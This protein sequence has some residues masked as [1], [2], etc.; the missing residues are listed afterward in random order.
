MK[1]TMIRRF[2]LLPAVLM[3]LAIFWLSSRTSNELNSVLP[4]FQELFPSMSNFDWGHFIAYF[5]LGLSYAYGFGRHAGRPS[6]KAFIILLCVVY[7]LTDEY[8][9]SF[10]AGRTPD[11]S[12]LLHDGIGA[13]LAMLLLTIPQVFKLWRKLAV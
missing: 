6:V 12:D 2:A 13:G 11:L 7:G 10:V 8:H 5:A 1:Q 4:W 9:Q 3:M